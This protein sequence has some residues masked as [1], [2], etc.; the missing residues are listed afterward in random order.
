MAFFT[1]NGLDGSIE[2]LAFSD[3]FTKY[4]EYIANETLAEEINFTSQAGIF[5]AQFKIAGST[6]TV[7]IK[8][9]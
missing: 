6:F 3:A 5:E 7:G 4:K 8:R 9:Y 2:A 1:L